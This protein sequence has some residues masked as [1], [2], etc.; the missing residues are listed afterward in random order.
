MNFPSDL[1]TKLS[2]TLRIQNAEKIVGQWLNSHP[3][4]QV[5]NVIA[6]H[7]LR[8]IETIALMKILPFSW[9]VNCVLA[10]SSKI[11]YR[12]TIE[13]CC[14]FHFVLPS[15]FGAVIY[16]YSKQALDL[17]VNLKALNTFNNF[18]Y[19][20][21]GIVLAAGFSYT[22]ASLAYSE[23]QNNLRL[24]GLKTSETGTELQP[25]CSSCNG[26]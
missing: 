1:C 14:N 12:L 9:G 21:S 5:I 15:I 3:R 2:T 13:R 25:I 18:T 4:A 16:G 22:I 7:A 17:I 8:I 11:I 19:A 10:L 6:M 24:T 26:V 23:V 20:S